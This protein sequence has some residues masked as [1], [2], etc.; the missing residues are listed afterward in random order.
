MRLQAFRLQ[1]S[2][3]TQCNLSHFGDTGR[4]DGGGTLGSRP[5]A[6]RELTL[7]RRQCYGWRLVV[8]ERLFCRTVAVLVPGLLGACLLAQAPASAAATTAAR[9]ASHA[10]QPSPARGA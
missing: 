7:V 8:L 10:G 4:P 3:S 1:L 5:R 2:T 9:T 6:P